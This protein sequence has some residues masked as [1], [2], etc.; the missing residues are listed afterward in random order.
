MTGLSIG[1]LVLQIF[2]AMGLKYL[3][4]IMNLLQF[5]IF[6]QM[7]TITFPPTTR[8]I[9]EQLRSLALLEF[10]PTESFTRFFKKILGMSEDGD[11]DEE[12]S[13]TCESTDTSEESVA[14]QET[15]I[16][17]VGSNDLMDN[18]GAMLA[19]AF[20]ILCIAVLLC[21]LKVLGRR[22][23]CLRKTYIAIKKKLFYNTF[24]RYILQSTLKL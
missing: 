13:E 17:R 1:I 7:W 18:M 5:L 11:C 6:M 2:L 22:C 19:I 4:N 15:G 16:D 8:I 21:L 24:L 14:S 9:L 23:N 10:I 3:W 12:S 20:I